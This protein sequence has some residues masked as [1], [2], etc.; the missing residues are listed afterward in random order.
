MKQTRLTL[1]MTMGAVV[2]MSGVL[3]TTVVHADR[4]IVIDKPERHRVVPL[5]HSGKDV[6]VP[7]SRHYQGVRVLRPHGRPFHG[8]GFFYSDA[9]AYRY[10]GL[11]AITLKIL[12]NINEEQQRMHEAA[13]ARATT[14]NVGEKIIWHEGNASGSVTTTRIGTSTSGRQCRE[15]QQTVTIG[16]QTET[17]YGTACQQPDG[18]WEI[19]APN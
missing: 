1:A 5:P 3:V 14:S 16:G 18:A 17:A 2:L 8:Y 10:L 11:T 19:V 12:D 4:V 15:F 9:D 7:R 13:Q 6:L